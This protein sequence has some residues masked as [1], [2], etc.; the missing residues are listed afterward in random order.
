[1]DA[2]IIN[3]LEVR[4]RVGVPD[5]ERQHPQ[6]L[7]LTVELNRDFS[8]A[9]A[10][11]ELSETIDYFAVCQRLLHWGESREWK[12]IERL[13]VEIAEMIL[14]DFKPDQVT[15]EVKKFIIPETKWVAVRV[16]RISNLS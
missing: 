15:V 14:A 9:V 8:A 7:L 3:D 16:R 10:K 13:A 5:A 1:M 6:R 12:L 4:Y 2:I 11:D